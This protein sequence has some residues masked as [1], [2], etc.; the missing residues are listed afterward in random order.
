MTAPA[1]L[2]SWAQALGGEVCDDPIVCRDHI[3]ARLG[4]PE[5]IACAKRL[6]ARQ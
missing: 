4:L 1:Q 3:R 2:G 5:L 6:E